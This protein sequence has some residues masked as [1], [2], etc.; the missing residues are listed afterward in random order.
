MRVRHVMG[1]TAGLSEFDPP[2]APEDLYDVDAI[3]AQLAGQAWWEPG[4]PPVITR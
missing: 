2:V 3:A 1:H 4:T